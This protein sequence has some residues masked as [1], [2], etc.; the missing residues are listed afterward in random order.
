[1]QHVPNIFPHGTLSSYHLIELVFPK[2]HFGKHSCGRQNNDPLSN[3][4]II[5]PRTCKYVMLQ[6]KGGINMLDGIKFDNQL[7]LK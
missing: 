2:T 1:M 6:D 3:V 7:T 4:Q 5:V